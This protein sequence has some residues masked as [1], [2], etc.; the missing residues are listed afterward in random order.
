MD[1]RMPLLPLDAFTW[2]VVHFLKMTTN[3]SPAVKCTAW[4][5][6]RWVYA[7]VWVWAL[8]VTF[9]LGFF[10]HGTPGLLDVCLTAP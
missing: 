10:A 4:R 5:N 1:Q 2:K 9:W 6:K 3:H 8:Y 7:L